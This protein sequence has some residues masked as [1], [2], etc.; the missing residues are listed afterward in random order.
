MGREL[1][2]SA[3]LRPRV[4][5]MHDTRTQ[6]HTALGAPPL[7]YAMERAPVM[8]VRL[9]TME[10]LIAALDTSVKS[11]QQCP[12]SISARGPDRV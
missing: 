6:P 12:T 2:I 10:K 4:M 9:L 7:V 3:M 11:A 8:H 1:T 5:V